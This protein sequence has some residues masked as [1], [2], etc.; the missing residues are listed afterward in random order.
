MSV[1]IGSL[2]VLGLLFCCLPGVWISLGF[3]Y[4]L[5]ARVVCF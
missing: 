1:V 4:L 5:F 3:T 2:R